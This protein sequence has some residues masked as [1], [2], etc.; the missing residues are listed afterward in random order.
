MTNQSKMPVLKKPTA[1][2]QLKNPLSNSE[3]KLLNTLLFNAQNIQ[4]GYTANSR[5]EISVREVFQSIGWTDSHNIDSLK[6]HMEKLMTTI[7]SWNEFEEDRSTSWEAC[8]FITYGKIKAGTLTYAINERIA[9]EMVRPRLFGKVQLLAQGSFSKRYSLIIYEYLQ[10]MIG[11]RKKTD[12]VCIDYIRS[13]TNLSGD[14]Y[15]QYKY[16]RRDVLLP[17]TEE[18]SKYSDLEVTFSPVR[19]GRST[20]Y[21]NFECKVK[22]SFQSSFDF[23]DDIDFDEEM[24]SEMKTYGINREAAIELIG[25]HGKQGCRNG[26]DNI[27]HA[28]KTGDSNIQ[29]TGA[30]LR[31]AIVQKWESPKKQTNIANVAAEKKREVEKRSAAEKDNKEAMD[32]KRFADAKAVFDS[33]PEKF[34]NEAKDAF[35]ERMRKQNRAIELGWH[36]K[37]GWRNKALWGC[38]IYDN[39][40]IDQ[41]LKDHPDYSKGKLLEEEAVA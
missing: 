22:K 20:R 5:Q 26:L 41:L 3:R 32:K 19:E 4:G 25:A 17:A 1:S 21:I 8:T 2:I 40:F 14:A 10:D 31:S 39:D 27:E 28:L 24:V 30:W 16:L 18:I 9:E 15:N 12:K 33:K 37:N 36:K 34:K 29:N 11:R 7:I 6:T 38:F 35:L 23:G 13:I